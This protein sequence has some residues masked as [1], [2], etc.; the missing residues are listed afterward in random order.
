MKKP[1]HWDIF[2]KV[3][4]NFGD[5]GVCWRLCCDLA[6]RGCQVRLWLD[7]PSA[8]RWM[9]PTGHPAVRVIEWKIGWQNH[10]VLDAPLADVILEG[11]GCAP[12]P[13]YLALWEELGARQPQ[14]PPPVWINLEY[15]SAEP[16]VERSHGLA[17]PTPNYA[18]LS[19][20]KFF[21]YPGF[22]A[23]TGGLI[24]ERTLGERRRNFKAQAFWAALDPLASHTA[25]RISTRI[26]LFCYS[27]APVQVWLE[28][29]LSQQA[30]NG[31]LVVY[32]TPGQASQ[33][34]GPA[35][36]SAALY[37]AQ[38]ENRLRW[39]NL[40]YLSQTDFDA[41]MWACDL[42]LVRGEDSLVRA[43]WAQKPFLWQL[44]PQHE[45]YHFNKLEAFLRQTQLPA[46][47]AEWMRL[48]NHPASQYALSE[49]QGTPP[50]MWRQWQ[51]HALGLA[52]TLE[53]QADLGTQL[54]Q[55]VAE[56]Q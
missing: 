41:L 15:L 37:Q 54:I 11:F 20:K 40:P 46:N 47:W 31:E 8:L 12:D 21:Y 3:I 27:K 45:D 43:I 13:Q 23:K 10:F 38:T 5:I 9:A 26:S 42:N 49:G 24:R 30:P 7:D 29:L 51:A 48:W 33:A 36:A 22:S 50:P 32:V 17:S 34:A 14:L 19:Q 28:G 35:Q 53:Q 56:R 55:F 39:V 25:H 44:Y 6:A 2:C 4:D 52:Q 18:W 1:K 16:Y